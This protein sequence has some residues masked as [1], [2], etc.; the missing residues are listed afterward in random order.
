M[1]VGGDVRLLALHRRRHHQKL[2][3]DGKLDLV[4]GVLNVV[5]EDQPMLPRELSA[6]LKIAAKLPKP[7]S[8]CR[9]DRDADGADRADPGV[10]DLGPA[11]DGGQT[12]RGDGR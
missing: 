4:K 3:Y 1:A 5:G 10:H 6:P 2:N 9:R 7:P 12:R 8:L 11:H